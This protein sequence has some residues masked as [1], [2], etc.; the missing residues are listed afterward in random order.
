MAT[1]KT[2]DVDLTEEIPSDLGGEQQH[3]APRQSG[4]LMSNEP[5]L[6]DLSEI[7][8]P[9]LQMVYGPGI[10]KL[11]NDFDAR[12]LVLQGKYCV[13]KKGDK[14]TAIFLNA[15]QYVKEYLSKEDFNEGKVA[16]TFPNLAAAAA[17]GMQTSWGPR[18][19]D[20]KP[21]VSSAM[22]VTLLIRKPEKNDCPLFSIN[23]GDGFEYAI[24]LLSLDKGAYKT[25]INDV[26]PIINGKLRQGLHH[27]LWQLFTDV[28][29]PSRS[30]GTQYQNIRADFK[31]LIDPA[32][33]AGIVEA[34]AVP[35]ND[36]E[37]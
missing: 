23:I 37:E 24:C 18:G 35:V 8:P 22:D 9:Y 36:V 20:M 10:G 2:A 32:V 1:K 16:A 33:A 4:A 19:S 7:R 6:L 5:L 12:D 26:G 28:S 11:S 34:M 13:A 27:G 14:L 25:F 17:A 29:A 30:T 31:G 3:L 15:K 21:N